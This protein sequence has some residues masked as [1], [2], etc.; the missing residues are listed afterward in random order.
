MSGVV[1]SKHDSNQLRMSENMHLSGILSCLPDAT[2]RL[3]TKGA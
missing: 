1:F 3:I 2:R